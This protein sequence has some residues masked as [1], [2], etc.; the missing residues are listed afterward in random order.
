M[1]YDARL[2]KDQAGGFINIPFV[3]TLIDTAQSLFETVIYRNENQV[4]KVV[5]NNKQFKNFKNSAMF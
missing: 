1:F 3:E 2:V 4:Y 5:D